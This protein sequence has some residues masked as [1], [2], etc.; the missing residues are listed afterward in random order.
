MSAV[1]IFVID[2]NLK[3]EM[4]L[5]KIHTQRTGSWIKKYIMVNK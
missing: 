1:T 5:L 2:Q 4:V 3:K